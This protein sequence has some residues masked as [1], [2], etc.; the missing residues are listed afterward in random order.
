M[1]EVN[2]AYYTEQ[3][4]KDAYLQE[5][6]NTNKLN[7]VYQL[8]VA[9]LYYEGP[10]TM[11]ELEEALGIPINVIC[12]RLN[13][14]RDDLKIITNPMELRFDKKAGKHVMKIQK[15]KNPT[16]EKWNSLWCLVKNEMK[17]FN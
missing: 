14:L 17:L 10:Q 2:T 4:R 12:G 16:T 9:R 8:I 7:E 6:V 1:K 15:K 11:Q 5:I 13:E 3:I